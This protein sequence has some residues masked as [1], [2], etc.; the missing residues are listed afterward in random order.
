[1]GSV[2]PN[3]LSSHLEL[4]KVLI[5]NLQAHQYFLNSPSVTPFPYPVKITLKREEFCVVGY[6]A[7]CYFETSVN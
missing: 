4:S 3:H 7:A 5:S 6:A 2:S 1:M